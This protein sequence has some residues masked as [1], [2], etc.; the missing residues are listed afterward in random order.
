MQ[1]FADVK[2]NCASGQFMA[3]QQASAAALQH[4]E[5]GDRTRVKYRRRLQK[6]VS[7][8]NQVGFKAKMPGGTYFL[9][10]RAPKACGERSFANA[11]EASQFL[12]GEQSVICVPW[13]NAGPY[14]RFSVTYL[15]RDEAEEDALMAETVKRLGRLQLRF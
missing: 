10:V 2:D 14:L 6:L 5:I 9:Y 1:A 4:P 7:A 3:I 11:E 15:A 12:I 8:L 13:D